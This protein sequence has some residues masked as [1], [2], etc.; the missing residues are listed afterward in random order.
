MA[1]SAA[2]T[3]IAVGVSSY[4]AKRGHD[5]KVQAQHRADE[6]IDNQNAETAQLDAKLEAN[7]AQAAQQNS[8]RQAQALRR[9]A[10]GRGGTVRTG[11]LGIPSTPKV[12]GNSYLGAA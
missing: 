9:G 1:I 2:A 10:L 3:A 8:F 7:K 4:Q 5:Q 6:A 11:P 12:G